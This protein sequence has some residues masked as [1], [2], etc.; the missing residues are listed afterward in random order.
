M[1]KNITVGISEE[2]SA[3][4]DEF[5]EVNWSAVTRIC[6]ENYINQRSSNKLEAAVEAVQSKKSLEFKKG[7]DFFINRIEKIDFSDLEYIANFEPTKPYEQEDFLDY[8]RRFADEI[9]PFMEEK[10]IK[11]NSEFIRGMWSAAEEIIKKT[12]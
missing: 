9:E 12:R 10:G 11:I 6:I 7:F 5:R 8:L 2:L 3:K 4:M 1:V